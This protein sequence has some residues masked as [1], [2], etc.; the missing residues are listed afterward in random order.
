MARSAGLEPATLGLEGRCS[1]Q[2]SYERSKSKAYSSKIGRG[3]GIRTPDP[4]VP[5]QLRYQ[6]ALCPDVLFSKRGRYYIA[7][8]KHCQTCDQSLINKLITTN[9]AALI[10]LG[11]SLG[12]IF[13]IK[14][15]TSI[16]V[17]F[18]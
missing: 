2:M 1:I 5:N 13:S 15:L 4:L 17:K 10:V 6:T 12:E 8:P 9:L 7:K 3:R 14:D 18:S 11:I 16:L